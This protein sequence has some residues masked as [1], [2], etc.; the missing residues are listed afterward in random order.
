MYAA[1]KNKLKGSKMTICKKNAKKT[2][3]VLKVT[4]F[5]IT[6]CPPTSTLKLKLNIDTNYINIYTKM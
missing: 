3:R 1:P 6:V 4:N 5:E 2:S